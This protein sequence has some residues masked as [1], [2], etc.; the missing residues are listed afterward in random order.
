MPNAPA[1]IDMLG[2]RVRCNRAMCEG[3][4]GTKE[5]GHRRNYRD[6]RETKT[7]TRAQKYMEQQRGTFLVRRMLIRAATTA[8]SQEHQGRGDSSQSL[9]HDSAEIGWRY[10][11]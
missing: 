11:E 7:R 9:D 3:C 6:Y 4:G 10:F 8:I 5:S 2:L 1:D